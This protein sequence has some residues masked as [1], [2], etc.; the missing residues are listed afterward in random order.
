MLTMPQLHAVVL[1]MDYAKSPRYPYPHALLQLYGVL[2][3]CLSASAAEELGVSIDPSRVA[4][5]GNSAGG[6][7]TAALSLLTAFA[8][9]PCARYRKEL[10]KEYCQIAQILLYPSVA[11]NELY[12]SRFAKTDSEAQA[13]SLPVWVAEMMEASYM[14]PLVNKKQI[15]IAP[16]LATPQ[17][18]SEMRPN[19]AAVSCYVAGLDCLK[20]EAIQY[21]QKL[22]EAGVKVQLKSYARAIHGFSHCPENSEKFR[23]DDFKD[24]WDSIS[25]VL[26]RAFRVDKD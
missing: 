24:C 5:M 19:I 15:F 3:W 13:E 18:L 9:G 26:E 17:L 12:R 22:E 21:C 2:K 10:P 14:P 16:L 11:C 6:N 8:E 23:K 1:S 4:I 7:L 25:H 20:N